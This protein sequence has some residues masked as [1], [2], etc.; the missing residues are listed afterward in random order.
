MPMSTNLAGPST[1][2]MLSSSAA[3]LGGACDGRREGFFRSTNRHD[4]SARARP[5]TAKK[6]CSTQHVFWFPVR[7][8]EDLLARRRR[9]GAEEGFP[10]ARWVKGGIGDSGNSNRIHLLAII[11]RFCQRYNHFPGPG[12]GL[13]RASLT[14]T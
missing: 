13:R 14:P 12:L 3:G 9:L 2:E 4:S 1:I 11:S 5:T 10:S 7:R 6:S 8:I